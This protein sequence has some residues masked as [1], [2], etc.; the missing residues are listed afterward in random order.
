[1]S[2]ASIV[3]PVPAYVHARAGAM[4]H[5]DASPAITRHGP[6]SHRNVPF[7]PTPLESAFSTVSSGGTG[8]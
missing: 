7:G 2:H 5:F 6:R 8:W 4:L 1:M 3:R